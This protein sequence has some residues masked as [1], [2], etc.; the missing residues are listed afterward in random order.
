MKSSLF[1]P[2]IPGKPDVRR[3]LPAILE[4][5]ARQLDRAGIENSRLEAEVLL[6][7]LLKISRIEL[8]TRWDEELPESVSRELQTL[9]SRRIGREPLA[10]IIGRKE[11]WSLC[12][13]VAPGVL[14][15]R[16]ETEFV[17]EAALRHAQDAVRI[18]DVGT[19]SGNIAVCLAQE[20]PNARIYAVDISEA[21]LRV[22]RR[23]AAYHQVI[24]RIIF[25]QADMLSAFAP[26]IPSGFIDCIVS[27]PP[28]ISSAEI[29]TLAPEVRVFEP[30]VA[31]EGGIDGLGCY[32]RLIH[33]S[34]AILK[35]GGR[36]ILEMGYGQKDALV[37]ELQSQ[38]YEVQEI[39]VDY[40]GIDR[41]IAARLG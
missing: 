40:A 9:L 16:P 38:G 24:E 17:I 18:I 37:R 35:A 2:D 7:H 23:N 12:F 36:I 34:T 29:S 6:A 14:I 28:Y 4:E 32:R 41:V 27:N 22:A 3:S 39:V 11:F 5:A 25:L 8:Y 26:D 1:R 31:L 19:G 20:L 13:M 15:P 33:E 21:A 30:R 10:Y